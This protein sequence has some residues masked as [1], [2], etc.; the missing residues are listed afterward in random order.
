MFRTFAV[1]N[2]PILCKK[3]HEGKI[4]RKY[5]CMK[6]TVAINIDTPAGIVQIYNFYTIMVPTP[7]HKNTKIRFYT[8][9][10]ILHVSAKHVAIIKV[11][12]F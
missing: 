2:L 7:A 5:L 3:R 10:E 11:I 1:Q 12:K 9:S 8:H 4:V 6:K